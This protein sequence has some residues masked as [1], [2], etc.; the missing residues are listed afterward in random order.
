MSDRLGVMYRGRIVEAGMRERLFDNPLHPYTHAL[1]ASIPSGITDDVREHA[2]IHE[3]VA[4]D[5]EVEGCRYHPR[6][7]LGARAKCREVD[8]GL[9]PVGP[10][11]RAACHFPQT[12]E[13]FRTEAIEEAIVSR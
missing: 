11:H 6:C 7:P 13:S 2:V 5:A 4:S 3:E 9:D 12:I 8:P 10:D 1:L